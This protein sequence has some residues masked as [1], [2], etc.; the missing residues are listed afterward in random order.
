MGCDFSIAIKQDFLN[1]VGVLKSLESKISKKQGK[2]E[3]SITEYNEL[4]SSEIDITSLSAKLLSSIEKLECLAQEIQKLKQCKTN[5][6]LKLHRSIE[7]DKKRNSKEK[8][9][10]IESPV[11]LEK[12]SNHR[13][14]RKK[15]HRESPRKG[16]NESILK[17]PEIL[18]LIN[19]NRNLLLRK[20]TT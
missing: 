13:I 12:N 11:N 2:I 9:Y 15:S 6:T 16:G 14:N 8:L 19:K 18:A 1:K 5:D 10:E 3:R 20:P 7:M 17:D 4:E